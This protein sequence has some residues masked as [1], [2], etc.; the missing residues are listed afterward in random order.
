MSLSSSKSDLEA[1]FQPSKLKVCVVI[2]TFFMGSP[3]QLWELLLFCFPFCSV[4][5]K[6][7]LCCITYTTYVVLHIYIYDIYLTMS[8]FLIFS[9]VSC[10]ESVKERKKIRILGL[11][12]LKATIWTGEKNKL[13]WLF[14]RR[15]GN[16]MV[17][18]V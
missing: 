6:R 14:L 12:S 18:W 11:L 3:Y 17:N 2:S 10:K 9:F 13:Y 15:H 7:W 8:Q 5:E 1:E 16:Q 4:N